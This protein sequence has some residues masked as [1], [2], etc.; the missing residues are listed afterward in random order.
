MHLDLIADHDPVSGPLFTFQPTTDRSLD[1]STV[2][3]EHG[4]DAPAGLVNHTGAALRISHERT[5]KALDEARGSD[6]G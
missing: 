4:V 2:P 6:E 5:R 1:T 3:E